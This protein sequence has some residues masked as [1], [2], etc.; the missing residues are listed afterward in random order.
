MRCVVF[1]VKLCPQLPGAKGLLLACNRT[2]ERPS[3]QGRVVLLCDSFFRVGGMDPDLNARL[4][5]GLHLRRLVSYWNWFDSENKATS[6]CLSRIVELEHPDVVIETTTERY[7]GTPPPDLER[8]RSA[9]ATPA[10]AN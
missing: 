8:F 6:D 7:L 1:E 4:P 5:L 2:L 9:L 3:G 10:P